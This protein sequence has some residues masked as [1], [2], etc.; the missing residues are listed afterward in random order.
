M[1]GAASGKNTGSDEADTELSVGSTVE[2]RYKGKDKYYRGVIA[3]KRINGTYDV[4]Y[5]DGE[6]ET[7]VAKDLIRL[8]GPPGKVPRVD[9]DGEGGGSK[10]ALE[11]GVKVEAR[12]KGKSKYY[13]GRI[14]RVRGDDTFDIDYDDGEKETRVARE[15]IRV[16]GAASGKNTGSDEA[17]TA[18]S[19][20]SKVEARYKGKD[21]YYPGRITKARGDDT[22]DI[23]YNDGEK[24]TGVAKDLIRLVGPP[25]SKSPDKV[26]REDG[27]GEGGGS[28]MALEEGVKVEARYKGKDK[29]YPGRIS[30]VRRD[31]TF[32][33]DYDDGEKE[34]GVAREL[35]QVLGAST[36]NSAVK[37]SGGADEESKSGDTAPLVFHVDDAVEARFRGNARYIPGIIMRVNDDG[38]YN[39]RY[40]DG[41][42]EIHVSPN[43][44]RMVKSAGSVKAD[45]QLLDSGAESAGMELAEES[46]L[47][48]GTLVEAKHQ[49]KDSHVR[50]V[51][52]RARLDGTY[53][54]AF[55]NGEKEIGV[56]GGLIRAVPCYIPKET[57]HL[58]VGSKIKARYGGKERYFP[59]V[60][61]KKNEDGSFDIDYDD[62]EIETH[63]PINLI[64][65]YIYPEAHATAKDETAA[66]NA[67]AK[68]ETAAPKVEKQ[69]VSDGVVESKDSS[70]AK[71]TALDSPL[72]SSTAA[73]NGYAAAKVGCFS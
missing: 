10:I 16:L 69:I 13:P 39:I 44:I 50:G 63:V 48:V 43:L 40:D 60:V 53:D 22:F 62:G 55:D 32:D 52:I 35:I 25:A 67:S 1:L 5:D 15:L 24:E 66:P 72:R 18:L 34:T 47:E 3:R 49:N 61:S 37:V 26:P 27:D 38:T 31:D 64:R 12:Y 33:V 68:E 6:K 71:E 29:Y 58:H 42:S 41:K 9:G 21:K 45:P 36:P 7:G 70:S 4:D 51:I 17:D 56:A 46:R 23:D 20:G 2:A 59:G 30:R 65:V 73:G 28:K 57:S 14:S 19:V 8:I 54:I 11:E